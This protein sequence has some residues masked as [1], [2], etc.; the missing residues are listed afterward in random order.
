MLGPARSFL[1]WS[2]K[3]P[4]T[5]EKRDAQT[6]VQLPKHEKNS[7]PCSYHYQSESTNDITHW[8]T[9]FHFDLHRNGV[10]LLSSESVVGRADRKIRAQPVSLNISRGGPSYTWSSLSFIRS[11]PLRSLTWRHSWMAFCTR[12]WDLL[13]SESMLNGRAMG[14]AA[15]GKLGDTVLLICAF[16]CSFFDSSCSLTLFF[17]VFFLFML[18]CNKPKHVR[19]PLCATISKWHFLLPWSSF[20]CFF[21]FPC[22]SLLQGIPFSFLIVFPFFPRN[23][24]G[25]EERKNPCLFGGFPC[26]FGKKKARKRRS[27]YGGGVYLAL[28]R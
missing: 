10:F 21:G 28:G 12:I 25:S 18:V 19:D 17:G 9:S 22:F 14:H 27:G 11:F 8:R 24:R 20:P 6:P 1:Y 13:Q 3:C 7:C 16:F 23:F 5:P 26:F 4:E 2:A 15:W